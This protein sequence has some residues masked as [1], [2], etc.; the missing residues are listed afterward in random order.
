MTPTPNRPLTAGDVKLLRPGDWLL[1][2]GHPV[3]FRSRFM[4]GIRADDGSG[5]HVSALPP[6]RFTFFAR[7]DNPNDQALPTR[8][9]H[10]DD[11]LRV[12]VE[13]DARDY[14]RQVDRYWAGE[15]D[16]AYDERKIDV[17]EALAAN[18]GRVEQWM[19]FSITPADL[20]ALA[21]LKGEG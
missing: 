13:D 21:A 19:R 16:R 17:A 9:A 20:A 5:K 7:P 4:G 2:D 8:P 10:T 12:A 3:R 11:K 6:G 14:E 15:A 1:L 18:G